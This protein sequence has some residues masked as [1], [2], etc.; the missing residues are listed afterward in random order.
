MNAINFSCYLMKS[1]HSSKLSAAELRIIFCVAAGLHNKQSIASFLYEHSPSCATSMI[2]RLEE[3]G[4]I[5]SMPH[6]DD[7]FKLTEYGKAIVHS[8]LSFLPKE[9]KK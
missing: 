4:F 8:T 7:S 6:T 2:N 9:L 1:I 5:A 3:R